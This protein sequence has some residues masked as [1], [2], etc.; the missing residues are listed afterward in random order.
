MPKKLISVWEAQLRKSR[1]AGWHCL[2]K[3][4]PLLVAQCFDKYAADVKS[5][6]HLDPRT[7]YSTLIFKEVTDSS[8]HTT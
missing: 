6:S 2:N 4:T 3:M 5:W 7:G 1:R 8:H